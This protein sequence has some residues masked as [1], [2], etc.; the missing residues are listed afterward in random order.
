[1]IAKYTEHLIMLLSSGD[2]R[3]Y[4]LRVCVEAGGCGRHILVVCCGESALRRDEVVGCRQYSVGVPGPGPVP[5]FGSM[6]LAKSNNAQTM[7]ARKHSRPRPA[8]APA[9][10]TR[11]A[12]RHRPI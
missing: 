7:P 6:P 1:M 11:D 2:G 12:V 8:G 5:G 4:T 10:P 9:W 3:L